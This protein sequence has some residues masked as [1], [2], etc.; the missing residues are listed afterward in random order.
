MDS[1]AGAGNVDVDVYIDEARHF[2]WE[3]GVLG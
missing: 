1:W 3:A 2:W